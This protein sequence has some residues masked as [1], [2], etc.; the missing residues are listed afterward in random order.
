ML[1]KRNRYCSAVSI[2]TCSVVTL[3]F[4]HSSKNY[5]MFR[6][7]LNTLSLEEIGMHIILAWL[8]HNID[9][10]GECILDFIVSNGLH[11]LNTMPFYSTFMKDNAI[12]SI[13]I[14]LCLSSILSFVS[15]WRTDVELDIEI[16]ETLT[17]GC[18]LLSNTE[19]LDKEV[20]FWA[21]CIIEAG[22]ATIGIRTIW[23]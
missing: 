20:E 11:I 6:K 3:I 21:K 23:K 14:T 22:E 15:N 17:I 8:D 10:M 5:N 1:I 9:D 7:L 2:E 18:N 19:I 16:E 12:S 4:K 13:D